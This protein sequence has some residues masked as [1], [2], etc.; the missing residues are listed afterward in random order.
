M[1]GDGKAERDRGREGGCWDRGKREKEEEMDGNERE[2]EKMSL[3]ALRFQSDRKAAK[4]IV[5]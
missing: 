3:N 1:K 4:F 5:K 2:R